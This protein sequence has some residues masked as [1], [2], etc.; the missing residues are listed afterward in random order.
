MAV[1]C[2]SFWGW[3]LE[4]V[5]ADGNL[6]GYVCLSMS[7]FWGLLCTFASIWGNAL[8]L[9][10]FHWIPTLI[11]SIILWI[12]VSLFLMDILATLVILQGR[13]KNLERW[14]TIDTWLDSFSSKL[15]KSIYGHVNR[16]IDKAYP[17]AIHKEAESTKQE[18]F[19]YGCS[20]HKIWWLFVIGAFLGDVVETLYCRITGGIW[21]SR[22]SVV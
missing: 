12:L 8:L 15:G 6:D 3:V 20:F 21:M 2:Y 16:R 11:G 7:A 13:S 22:S 14:E 19:A 10:L 18:I 5:T 4:T 1:L 17:E 9:K